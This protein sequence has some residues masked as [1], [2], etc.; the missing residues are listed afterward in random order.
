MGFLDGYP[1]LAGWY[2]RVMARPSYAVAFGDWNEDKYLT[3]MSEKGGEVWP[4]IHEMIAEA[5]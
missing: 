2:D 4:R 3:L 1:N 5:A